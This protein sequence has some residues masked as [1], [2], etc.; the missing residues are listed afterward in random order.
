M[1]S[2]KGCVQSTSI[3]FETSV[4]CCLVCF[5]LSWLLMMSGLRILRVL[6]RQVLMKVWILFIVAMVEQYRLH[7]G[8]ED[9]DVRAGAQ[10]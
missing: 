1:R 9:P 5:Y 10:E 3:V 6:L 7:D 2:S 8:V 4:G